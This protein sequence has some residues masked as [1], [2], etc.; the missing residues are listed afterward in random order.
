[1]AMAAILTIRQSVVYYYIRSLIHRPAVCFGGE[2]IKSPSVLSLSAS[3]KHIIQILE[4]LDER[5]LSLSVS[6]NRRELVFIAGLGLLW[7]NMGLKRDSKLVKES[8]KLLTSVVNQLES[9]SP[10]AATE[11]SGVA[12][13]LVSLDGRRATTPK[14]AM[15]A[16]P[17]KPLK[18]PKKQMQSWKQRLSGA[19]TSDAPKQEPPLSRRATISGTKPAGPQDLRSPS[20]SSLP[21]V[22]SEPSQTQY[23]G[24][25]YLAPSSLEYDHAPIIPSS[26]EAV[27]GAMTMADWEYVLSDM[28]QGYSNI[29]T[30][31][32]GG[33]ECG[34]DHGPFASLTGQTSVPM[35]A[36]KQELP[37][38]SPESWS[39][40][41]SDIPPYLENTNPSVL[42]YSEES[43]HDRAPAYELPQGSGFVDPFR[44]MMMPAEEDEIG[45][46]GLA[47][48]W[49]RRLA[50]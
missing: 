20:R 37:E 28:D 35:V 10:E 23:C 47:E 44:G 41:S 12:N 18:F 36:P 14:Q 25:Q 5:C 50:V 39:A 19:A 4:L 7:Q 3:S 6:I 43:A 30:G 29:F 8:Q 2:Q 48:E 24:S 9:E 16:P 31:I 13:V 38:L 17:E 33:K 45:E 27:N 15:S 34:E 1:M 42:S 40:S 21:S 49:D 11:F 26:M 32:Y 22:Y 46:F